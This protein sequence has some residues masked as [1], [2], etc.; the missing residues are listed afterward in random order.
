[1]ATATSKDEA[2]IGE[3]RGMPSESRAVRIGSIALLALALGV[4][5]ILW[6][7]FPA[8]GGLLGVA[9]VP[10]AALVALAS[11]WP[12]GESEGNPYLA[13][14]LPVLLACSFVM[15]PAAAGIV[16]LVASTSRQELRGRMTPSRCVWNHAQVALSVMAAGWVFAA[17]QGDVLD[18]PRVLIAAEAALVADTAVNYLAVSLIYAMGSGRRFTAVL[19]TLHIG[20][21]RYFALF[22]ASLAVVAAVMATLYMQIGSFALLVFAVPI[23]LARETLR[24]TLLADTAS[25]DLAVRREALRRVDERI[26]QERRDERD[27]IASAI[28]DEILQGIFD[29]TIRAHVI[30]ECYRRGQ[31]LALEGEVPLLVDSAERLADGTRDMV[32][33]LRRSPIGHAGLV[34]TLSL[35]VA[36]I[37]DKT[38]MNIVSE[39]TPEPGLPPDVELTVYQ[40]AHQALHNAANHSRA[41]VIWLSLSR[42]GGF[43]ELRVLDNGVGFDVTNRRDKHFGLEIMDERATVAG[44]TLRVE[45]SPG[46][47]A[48]VVARFSTTG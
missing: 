47:G 48:L 31:L 38:G 6:H 30:K 8:D 4:I 1:M 46:N 33:G 42:V 10:W 23:L 7:A 11:V 25:R 21:P 2:S 28:H 34:E 12:V 39:I 40:I 20:T 9:L 17:M 3:Q 36:D 18:W 14:D 22:Y 5:R 29:I 44:G 19:L 27:R 32:Y 37:A 13:L 15:G 35:L 26:A 24:Q 41:D 43:V 45:S 16:A